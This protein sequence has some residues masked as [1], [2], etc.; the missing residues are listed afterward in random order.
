[1]KSFLAIVLMLAGVAHAQGQAVISWP[2]PTTHVDNTPIVLP[3]TYQVEKQSGTAWNIVATVSALTYTHT[4]LAVGAHCYRVRAIVNLVASDPSNVACKTVVQPAPRPPVIT[5]TDLVAGSDHAPVFIVLADG[6][7]SSTWV[8]FARV[9]TECEGPTLF[10]YLN[11]EWRKP[12]QWS[13][14]RGINTPAR[15]AAPCA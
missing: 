9:G 2:A 3:I 1:M 7:R 13:I 5:V 4:N 8:G 14:R 6:T 11:T 15:V 10:R 12:V